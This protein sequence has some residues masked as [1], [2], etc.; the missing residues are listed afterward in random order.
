MIDTDCTY[1]IVYYVTDIPS[2]LIAIQKQCHWYSTGMT[3]G[4]LEG[5]WLKI[6]HSNVHRK[7]C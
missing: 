2:Y 4:Q 1:L 5:N 7:K 3:C 6:I